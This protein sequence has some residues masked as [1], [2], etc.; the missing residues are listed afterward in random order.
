MTCH[1]HPHTHHI[2]TLHH[3]LSGSCSYLIQVDSKPA[4]FSDNLGISSTGSG[5]PSSA[6]MQQ[7]VHAGA[8]MRVPGSS[9]HEGIGRRSHS[10]A[11]PQ[12]TNA[13]LVGKLHATAGQYQV[14]PRL[15]YIH[16]QQQSP[17]LL[18]PPQAQ[19]SSASALKCST[20]MLEAIHTLA[21]TYLL[22]D[23]W[24]SFNDGVASGVMTLYGSVN[25]AKTKPNVQDIATSICRADCLHRQQAHHDQQ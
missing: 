7:P 8:G 2:D 24:V 23:I 18:C 4:G 13:Q 6:N 1:A 21:Q 19:H 14:L 12:P 10:Q 22:Q 16:A 5:C 17:S 25:K 20:Q 9:L 3:R 15:Q 11:G